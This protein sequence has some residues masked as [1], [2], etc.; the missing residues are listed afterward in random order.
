MSI[1]G[2]S[3][4][5]SVV[6]SI[7]DDDFLGLATLLLHGDKCCGAQGQSGPS[8]AYATIYAKRWSAHGLDYRPTWAT[9]SP[10]SPL[11]ASGVRMIGGRT[12][13]INCAYVTKFMFRTASGCLWHKFAETSR[14]NEN[15]RFN[16]DIFSE[17]CR[18]E[19][20]FD[21][22]GFHFVSTPIIQFRTPGR[23]KRYISGI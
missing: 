4:F 5:C 1:L 9:K 22:P 3:I 12:E 6:L 19:F 7:L 14:M 23:L 13:N 15:F 16:S 21:N 18:I 11:I 8:D 17:T 20:L 10:C 2:L